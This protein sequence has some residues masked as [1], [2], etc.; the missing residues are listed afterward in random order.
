MGCSVDVIA[1]G[2]EA[3]PMWKLGKYDIIFMDL[4]M[5]QIDGFQAT[6]QIRFEE[7][8]LG[9]PKTPIVAL[10]ASE[11][12]EEQERCKK[13][14]MDGFL[15]RPVSAEQFLEVISKFKDSKSKDEVIVLNP[16]IEVQVTAN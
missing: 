16:W 2:E 12:S 1:D 7:R 3:V 14:G 4:Y 13:V 8:S 5:A 6:Q 10:T 15:S 9:L 11:S